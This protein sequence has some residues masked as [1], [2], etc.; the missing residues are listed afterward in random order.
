MRAVAAGIFE[1]ETDPV[2]G[3]EV[4]AKRAT[5]AGRTLE[6]DGSTYYFCADDCKKKFE[7]DPAAYIK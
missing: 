3:M 5:A 2:C 4:D 7:A 1:A 6:H